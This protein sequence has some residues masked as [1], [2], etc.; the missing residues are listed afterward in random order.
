MIDAVRGI[1]NSAT[2]RLGSAVAERFAS[3]SDV[4]RIFYV[5]GIGAARPDTS[6]SECVPISRTA[7]L[8]R[9]LKT[10]LSENKIDAVVHAMAVS[11]YRVKA[12][13]T[14]ELLAA[15]LSVSLANA[16]GA[17]AS[18]ADALNASGTN[19]LAP[20]VLRAVEQAKTL[21]RTEKLRSNEDNLIL[22]MEKTPKVI[23]LY[24]KMS[25]NSVLVGFKLL[26]GVSETVLIDTAFELLQRNDCEFVL[27]NDKQNIS[28]DFSADGRK[29]RS[30]DRHVGYLVDRQKRVL[31][32]NTKTEIAD[33]IVENVLNVLKNRQF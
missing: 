19:V 7:E 16:S 33:G 8:E 15:S 13:T 27:A 5:C 22:L 3:V 31:R 6:K 1:T 21:D 9:T 17:D 2:G 4:E 30:A 10:I 23:E 25:P 24:K 26:D 28:W 18:G 12:A 11:D 14:A 32:Y 20:L 29:T